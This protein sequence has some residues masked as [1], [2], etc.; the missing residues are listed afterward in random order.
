MRVQVINWYKL[1]LANGDD[2]LGEKRQIANFFLT[3]MPK[4]GTMG[5]M[6]DFLLMQARILL[7]GQNFIRHL[8]MPF[9]HVSSPCDSKQC[10][11]HRCSSLP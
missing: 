9:T 7:Q 11:I 1:D 2:A 10:R 5:E 4:Y 3:R 8:A 6:K